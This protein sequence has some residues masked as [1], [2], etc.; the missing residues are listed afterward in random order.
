MVRRQK[1]ED[2]ASAEQYKIWR[3]NPEDL[4]MGAHH[5]VT[6]PLGGMDQEKNERYTP[7]EEKLPDLPALE[8]CL[9]TLLC[10]PR[11]AVALVGMDF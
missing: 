11:P 5:V 9:T 2:G 3:H 4:L 1:P 7:L 6:D 8:A 10:L